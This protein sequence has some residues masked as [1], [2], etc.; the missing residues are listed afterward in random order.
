MSAECNGPRRDDREEEGLSW[1]VHL[2]RMKPR[3]ALKAGII[4]TVFLALLYWGDGHVIMLL[5]AT[6]ALVIALNSFIFPLRYRLDQRGVTLKTIL[7]TQEYR[8]RRFDTYGFHDDCLELPFKGR[9]IRSRIL[10]SVYL[11]YPEDEKTKEA[12]VAFA[13][14]HVGDDRDAPEES[15]SQT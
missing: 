12:I 5:V 13:K 11:Y 2:A 1:S 4:A 6:S 15:R 8:W 9:G 10:R 14:R 3:K 7:G